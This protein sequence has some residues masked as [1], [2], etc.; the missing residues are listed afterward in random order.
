MVGRLTSLTS[1]RSAKYGDTADRIDYDTAISFAHF[2]NA[3]PRRCRLRSLRFSHY[4]YQQ[5]ARH[6]AQHDILI[7]DD[8]R[9]DGRIFSPFS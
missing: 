6:E 1:C 9:H 8:A 2:I 7:D 3:A 4:L 5:K